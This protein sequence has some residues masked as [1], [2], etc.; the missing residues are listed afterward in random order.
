MHTVVSGHDGCQQAMQSSCRAH[1]EL[2][3]PAARYAGG[4]Q[5]PVT[6][7]AAAIMSPQQTASGKLQHFQLGVPL[8][9]CC[10]RAIFFNTGRCQSSELPTKMGLKADDRGDVI[11]EMKGNV[12]SVHG[13]YVAGGRTPPL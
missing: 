3:Q 9:P 5:T 7:F 11:C 1:A 4:T 12:Q 10:C 13:L 2:M 6:S 8:L